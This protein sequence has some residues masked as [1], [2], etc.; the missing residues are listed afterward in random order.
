MGTPAPVSCGDHPGTERRQ[1]ARCDLDTAADDT[2][3]SEILAAQIGLDLT[4]APAGT[5][6]GVGSASIPL[7]YARVQLRLT[8]GREQRQWS[9][10]AGFTSATIPYPML[11]FAGCLQFFIATFHGDREEIELAVNGLYPGT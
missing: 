11:G 4:G 2:I 5:G 10:W 6:A 7:R 1:S 3:F 8:D 9:A